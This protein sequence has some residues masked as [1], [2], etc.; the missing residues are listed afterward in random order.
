M[1]IDITIREEYLLLSLF[2]NADSSHG[3]VGLARLHSRYLCGEVHNEVLQLPVTSVGPFRQQFWLQSRR[4]SRI[5]EIERRHGRIG[6]HAQGASRAALLGN[7]HGRG[8]VGIAPTIQNLLVGAVTADFG[9]K[10]VEVLLQFGI[11]Q[12]VTGS[13]RNRRKPC[14]HRI[15]LFKKLLIEHQRQA[16]TA[17]RIYFA[18]L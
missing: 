9:Q 1:R 8:V 3:H 7:V 6:C 14:T 5:D 18:V 16:F 17:R 15:H 13:Y 10:T 12:S 2:G 4:F 11:V